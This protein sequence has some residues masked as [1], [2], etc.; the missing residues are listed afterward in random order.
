MKLLIKGLSSCQNKLYYKFTHGVI[1]FKL[2]ILETAVEDF[3]E[4]SRENPKESIAHF[5]YA[6][7][8]FQLGWYTTSISIF[9]YLIDLILVKQSIKFEKQIL[10]DSYILKA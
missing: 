3:E 1:M 4:V 2:G 5:N 9:E 7:T 6:L 8:L 10:F